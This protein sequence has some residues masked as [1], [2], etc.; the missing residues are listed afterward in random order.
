MRP[1]NKFNTKKLPIS[2]LKFFLLFG[3]FR[4]KNYEIDGI[5]FSVSIAIIR[6][7]MVIGYRFSMFTYSPPSL[8]INKERRMG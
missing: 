2:F 4:A 3:I 8:G 7:L 1:Q 6:K 5:H